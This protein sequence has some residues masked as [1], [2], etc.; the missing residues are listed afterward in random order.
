MSISGFADDHSLQKVFWAGDVTDEQRSVNEI[1]SCLF[2][3]GTWMN[4]NRLKM[5]VQNTELIFLGSKQQ[6]KKC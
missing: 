4:E 1:E 5:N 2:N 6:L 3:V